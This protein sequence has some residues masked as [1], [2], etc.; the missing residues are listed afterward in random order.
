MASL[1]AR[2]DCSGPCPVKFWVS[3]RLKKAQTF[4]ALFWCLITS[5]WRNYLIRISFAAMSS[6]ASYLSTVPL[7]EEPGSIL[8]LRAPQAGEDSHKTPFQHVLLFRLHAPSSL[9]VS[10]HIRYCSLLTNRGSLLDLLQSVSVSPALGSPRGPQWPQTKGSDHFSWPANTLSLSSLGCCWFSLPQGH[11]ADSCTTC[12]SLRLPGPVLQS[13]LLT[14]QPMLHE[15]VL[16][17]MQGFAFA[18]V[19]LCKIS[20]SCFPSLLR[21]PPSSNPALQHINSFPPASSHPQTHRGCSQPRQSLISK[22]SRSPVQKH[23]QI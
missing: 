11:T 10:W 19:G 21:I 20:A 6:I 14:S 12:C 8:S 22:Y 9:R 13:C 4:W 18:F 2:S 7:Q 17:H 16:S 15:I 5:T 3:P 23:Y 1:K